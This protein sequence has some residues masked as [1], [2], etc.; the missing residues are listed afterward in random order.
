MAGRS[1][2][3]SARKATGYYAEDDDEDF[4]PVAGDGKYY[5]MTNSRY[6]GGNLSC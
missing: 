4:V 5:S 1:T 6:S 3:S 2:R